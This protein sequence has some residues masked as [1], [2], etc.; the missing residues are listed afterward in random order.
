M[1]EK[2]PHNVTEG[3]YFFIDVNHQFCTHNALQNFYSLSPHTT[4]HRDVPRNMGKSERVE[5]QESIYTTV[6]PTG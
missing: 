1:G 3:V 4:L 5:G 2:N 6:G